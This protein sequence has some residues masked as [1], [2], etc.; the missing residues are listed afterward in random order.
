M[1]T[2]WIVI[3]VPAL[4]F[5]TPAETAGVWKPCL[6]NTRLFPRASQRGGHGEREGGFSYGWT[7]LFVL[8]GNWTMVPTEKGWEKL[9]KPRTLYMAV[10][11][12]PPLPP[13]FLTPGISYQIMIFII[14]PSNPGT[15]IFRVPETILIQSGLNCHRV[16]RRHRLKSL[17]IARKDKEP[18][19]T[20]RMRF[21][22]SGHFC[23]MRNIKLP[24]SAQCTIRLFDNSK[25][26]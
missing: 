3:M 20:E 4:P 7:G 21:N 16:C 1:D 10:L 18:Y 15:M 9:I 24:L 26:I 14:F 23:R 13:T 19:T 12:L 8:L 17:T 6:L 22:T 5:A 2:L 25:C 11:G